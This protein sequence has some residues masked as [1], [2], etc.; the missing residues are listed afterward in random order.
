VFKA[1]IDQFEISGADTSTFIQPYQQPRPG[2][3]WA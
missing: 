2:A 3:A 1:S